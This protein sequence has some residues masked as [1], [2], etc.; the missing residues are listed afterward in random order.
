MTDSGVPATFF[1]LVRHGTTEA[2][3]ER[4]IQGQADSPLAAESVEKARQWGRMLAPMG[5][6]RIIA[7]D[8]GRARRTAD[9]I[10][11]TLDLDLV[12]D[13][14]LRELDW[15]EWVG[16]TVEEIR[17][18][19]PERIAR[20]EALGWDFAPPGGESR[21]NHWLRASA[22]LEDAARR[23]PGSTILVVCHNGTLKALVYWLSGRRFLPGEPPLIGRRRHLHRIRHE[24]GGLVLEQANALPLE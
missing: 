6:S 21:R 22:A 9:L 8:L 17:S 19:N 10:N 12:E 16:M 15:G 11:E 14:R 4:R 5:F 18:G 24:A 2:N 1:G 3:L 20:L 7:S 13:P 23:T